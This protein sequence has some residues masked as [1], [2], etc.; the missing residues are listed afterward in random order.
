MKEYG[1]SSILKDN[2]LISEKKNKNNHGYENRN[3][4]NKY[5]IINTEN[6]RIQEIGTRNN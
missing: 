6:N 5:Q 3:L 1:R 2:K 4:M